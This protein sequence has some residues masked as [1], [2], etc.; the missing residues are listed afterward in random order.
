MIKIFFLIIIIIRPVVAADLP[1]ITE[2][3]KIGTFLYKTEA[4][5]ERGTKL[6]R[7]HEKQ[8]Q[9]KRRIKNEEKQQRIK[10]EMKI[11][12]SDLMNYQFQF[13]N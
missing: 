7:K 8:R 6:D 3:A 1:T 11:R 5:Q 13:R 4:D 12:Q 10:P 9:E 2:K